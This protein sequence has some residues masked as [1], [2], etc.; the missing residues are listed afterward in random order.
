M[1]AAN[2]LPAA[3]VYPVRVWDLP[4]RLFHWALAAAVVGL[5][6]TGNVGG[7]AMVWHLRLGY[8]VMTLLLFRLCWGLLGGHW[9]RFATF[10]YRPTRLLA[11]LRGQSTAD[12]EVGHSPLGALAVWAMLLAL[13][14]QVGSGL[15]SDDEIAFLGP[16][17]R[18]AS[19]DTVSA[20]TSYH[21][22]VG[23]LVVLALV[24]LHVLAL[25]VYKLVKR[26]ALVA[27]MVS[28]DKVLAQPAQASRDG[29][30]QRLLAL[31]VLL[32]C[33]LVVRWVASLG[34][35]V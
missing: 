24:L 29:W 7:N 25:V 21:K 22:D 10:L 8:A 33:A 28:G 13:A 27:A 4:T 6:I 17:T 32:V 18:F 26:R 3:H 9:S 35:A 20:L 19:Y 31:A 2:S 14:V 16:L 1:T 30:P 12:E 23:K 15:F 34:N 5:V 11:Y